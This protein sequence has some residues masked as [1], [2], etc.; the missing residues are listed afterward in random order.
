MFFNMQKLLNAAFQSIKLIGII[1]YFIHPAQL[2]Y[3]R[4]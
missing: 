3:Y 2:Q 1:D 4:A